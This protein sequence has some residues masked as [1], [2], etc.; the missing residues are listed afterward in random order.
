MPLTVLRCNFFMNHLLKT[1]ASQIQK[2]G[3]FSN[4]LGDSRNSFVS[5]SDVGE[6]AALCLAEGAEKHADKFYDLTGPQPQSMREIAADL[7][8]ALGGKDVEFRPQR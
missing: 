8:R 5:T 7:G 6:V 3:W 1:D 2:D 4:P